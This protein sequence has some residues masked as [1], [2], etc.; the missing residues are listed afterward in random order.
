[1]L[2]RI[3]SGP[4]TRE[5]HLIRLEPTSML[6][7]CLEGCR[8]VCLDENGQHIKDARSGCSSDGLYYP[9]SPSY[10]RFW[11]FLLSTCQHLTLPDIDLL[12]S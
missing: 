10:Q 4:R 9:Q 5:F 6:D 11:Y 1:M 12:L 8:P 2:D 7:S 3:Q